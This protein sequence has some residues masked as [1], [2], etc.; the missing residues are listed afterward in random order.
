MM[1]E[2]GRPAVVGWAVLGG[3]VAVVLLTLWLMADGG[4]ATQALATSR[5]GLKKL[6]GGEPIEQRQAAERDAVAELRR[7]VDV[8]KKRTG[9]A[10]L[11]QYRV[12]VDDQDEKL[13][14]P[15][16]FF[17]QS[18]VAVRDRVRRKAFNKS[19]TY[20]EGLGFDTSDKVPPDTD[21]EFLLTMLQ[22]TEKAA[23][24]VLDT[25]NPVTS[26]AFSRIP[27]KKPIETGPVNRP[28]LV[29]EY[30]MELKV[31]GGLE[32]LLWILHRLSQ[33]DAAQAGDFPLI[34]QSLTIDSQNLTSRDEISQLTATFKIAGMQFLS[35]EE[36]ARSAG[37]PVPGS[38]GADPKEHGRPVADDPTK[39][40]A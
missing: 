24:I 14:Q 28:V 32:D 40:R 13:R 27:D 23:H 9:F 21:A 19:I 31:V 22:L 3:T 25:P 18:L 6:R 12:P 11:K 7:T 26:F 15:G 10:V 5:N 34:L 38:G 20:D 16:Y 29:R 33:V 30:P 35:D 17:K 39:P 8:L 1:V 36:R 2:P 4:T 37:A